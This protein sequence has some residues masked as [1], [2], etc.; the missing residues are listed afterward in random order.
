MKI[1]FLTQ[2]FLSRGVVEAIEL[3]FVLRKVQNWTND[4]SQQL[5]LHNQLANW[6]IHGTPLNGEFLFE[7]HRTFRVQEN[8]HQT[9]RLWRKL[10]TV[11]L[12]QK[13]CFTLSP[14]FQ[15]EE[16]HVSALAAVRK[17]ELEKV[18]CFGNEKGSEVDST[19]DW[20]F[21]QDWKLAGSAFDWNF[22]SKK[23]FNRNCH[24]TLLSL[25]IT[26]LLTICTTRMSL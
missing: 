4:A 19:L 23:Y 11:G 25:T 14:I 1:F 16:D 8:F 7:L 10:E 15:N 18:W 21:N 24:K 9:A 6:K 12:N 20:G 26:L 2:K 22:L 3:D 17:V 13:V 5:R